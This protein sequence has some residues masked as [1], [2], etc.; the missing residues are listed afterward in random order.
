MTY[1]RQTQ[2]EYEARVR[3]QQ[4]KSLHKKARALGMAVIETPAPATA[5]TV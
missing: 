4:V 3:E 5:P 2:E 1:V